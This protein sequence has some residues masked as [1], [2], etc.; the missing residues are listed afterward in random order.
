MELNRIYQKMADL[1]LIFQV[2]HVQIDQRFLKRMQPNIRI[3]LSWDLDM[4]DV[5]LLVTEPRGER[6]S[7]FQNCSSIGG[8][9]SKNFS[10]GYGPQEYLVCIFCYAF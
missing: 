8:I 4:S 3:I 10:G 1:G 5:E 9:M 6:V 7:S 2:S